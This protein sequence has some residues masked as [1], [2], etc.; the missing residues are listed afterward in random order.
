MNAESYCYAEDLQSF[1]EQFTR[2]NVLRMIQESG[3]FSMNYRLMVH[4]EPKQVTLKAV[5][6]K[7]EN[8]E[9]LLIGVRTWRNRK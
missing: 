9:K 1:R 5:L 3:G 7:N 8:T 4:D 2:E 6:L